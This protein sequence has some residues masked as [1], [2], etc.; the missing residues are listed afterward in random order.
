MV[1][2]TFIESHQSRDTMKDAVIKQDQGIKDGHFT[3]YKYYDGEGHLFL[4]RHFPTL[5]LLVLA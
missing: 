5:I 1:E 2:M 4:R 3:V